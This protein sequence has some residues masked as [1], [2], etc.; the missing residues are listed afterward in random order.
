MRFSERDRPYVIAEIGANHNGDMEQAR[1]HVRAAKA[2]GADAAKKALEDAAKAKEE[3]R[4]KLLAP[5]SCS[6]VIAPS[7]PRR[8][9]LRGMTARERSSVS[10]RR[11]NPSTCCTRRAGSVTDRG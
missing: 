1:A 5:S 6:V 10:T 8:T 3:E 7:S 4:M 9:R 2:A 11:G